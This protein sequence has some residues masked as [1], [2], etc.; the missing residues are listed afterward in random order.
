LPADCLLIFRRRRYTVL[1][2]SCQISTESDG[3]EPSS[4]PRRV[5]LTLAVAR[6]MS[7]F[8]NVRR[9]VA[10]SSRPT[11]QLFVHRRPVESSSTARRTRGRRS[12]EVSELPYRKRVRQGGL[13]GRLGVR[14]RGW[15]GRC[16]SS[17]RP[18]GRPVLGRSPSNF[19]VASAHRAFTLVPN[20]NGIG[21]K[22]AEL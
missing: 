10:R 22:R 5:T 7:Y 9:V 11:C 1:P 17:R 2:P 12:L 6:Q 14:V 13:S 18:A 8:Q 15:R 16:V 19:R 21:R 20:F 3:S 4:E